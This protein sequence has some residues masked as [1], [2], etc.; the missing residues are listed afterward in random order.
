MRRQGIAQKL[1][2]RCEDAARASGYV[3]AL[4]LHVDAANAP[5]RA[6]YASCGFLDVAR[7]SRLRWSSLLTFH[8]G[9]PG[10]VLMVKDL[11]VA[12]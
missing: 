12:S 6:L 8:D 10:L 11:E 2:Q 9:D 4:A 5:A 3:V 1:V 7:G